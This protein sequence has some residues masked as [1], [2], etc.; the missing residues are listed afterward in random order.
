MSREYY[1]RSHTKLNKHKMGDIRMG[2]GRLTT[3]LVVITL[4]L[5]IQLTSSANVGVSPAAILFKDVL[6]GGYAERPIIITIDTQNP[7]SATAT[8]RGDIASWIKFSEQNFTITKGEPHQLMISVTPPIDTPNGNYTGFITIKSDRLAN[9]KKGHATGLIIPTLDVYVIVQVT[10]QEL[11][12]CR[13]SNFK[14][15]SV[16]EGEDI[17]FEVDVLNQGNVRLNPQ[18]TFDIWDQDSVNIVKQFRY[19]QSQITPT[20]SGHLIIKIPSSDLPL[21]Q[22]WVDMQAI[23]CYA[24]QTLTFDVLEEGALYAAGVLQRITISPWAEIGEIVPIS[25]SFKNIGEKPLDAK[26][27]GQV[28][29]KNKI[30]QLFESDQ[31]LFVP[32]NNQSMFQFYFTPQKAGK[33]VISGRVFYDNKRTYEQSAILNVNPNP[34]GFKSIAKTMIYIIL[35]IIIITLL[36]KIRKER[37]YY[38]NKIRKYHRK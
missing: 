4:I 6:R 31:E 38:F 30:I 33:Y 24:S 35:I 3:L 10:D 14:T 23:E 34:N 2:K 9:A 11:V 28:K 19:T 8:T 21:G 36:Y 12:S 20:Q 27:S 16:E 18:I 5:V 22:Y 32:I 37:K 13:A 1:N 15:T 17:I 25:I 29:F 7:T 26:F